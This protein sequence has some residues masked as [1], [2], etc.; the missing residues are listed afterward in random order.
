MVP[1]NTLTT[2]R[3]RMGFKAPGY[4]QT[5]NDFFDKLLPDMG[6]AELKVFCIIMRKTFG[7]NKNRD[8]ISLAQLERFTKLTRRHILKAI[9]ILVE[10]QLINKYTEGK[11][12]TQSTYYELVVE[13]DSNNS[14]QCPKDTPPSILRTPTKE[15]ITKE[16]ISPIVPK[17][18]PP[19]I[20]KRKIRREV[21]KEV[22]ERVFITQS[23]HENLLKRAD[24]NLSLVKSWYDRLSTWKI[25]KEIYGG[26]RDY[27][28]IVDWVIDAVREKPFTKKQIQELEEKKREEQNRL[29]REQQEAIQNLKKKKEE[30]EKI[31]TDK[32]I[33]K[34]MPIIQKYLEKFPKNLKLCAFVNNGLYELTDAKYDRMTYLMCEDDFENKLIHRLKEGGLLDS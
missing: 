7:W 9:K 21:K 26:T 5:P 10:K 19:D 4:T 2:R 29:H 15:T 27:K 33:A 16:I 17:G 30:E 20:P 11:N 22:A 31:I 23:Q 12:G 8:R 14:Y 24:N 25:D 1:F 6:L 28:G 3:F 34:N 13:D 18:D 32:K